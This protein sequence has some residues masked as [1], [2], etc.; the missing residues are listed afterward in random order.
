MFGVKVGLRG[1][2]IGFQ[3]LGCMARLRV[4]AYLLSILVLLP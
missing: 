2:S 3:G 1:W 4:S